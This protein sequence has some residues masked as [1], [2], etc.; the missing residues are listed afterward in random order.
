MSFLE[1]LFGGV[2]DQRREQYQDFVNRYEQGGPY[3]GIGADE[4]LQQYQQVA[5]QI[6]PDIYQQAAQEAFSRMA[7]QE[8]VQF[9]QFLERQ[10]RQQG[11]M[12]PAWD[13]DDNYYQDPGYLAQV[14]SRLQQQKS[15]MLA[16]LLGGSLEG[17]PTTDPPRGSMH[18]GMTSTGM[19]GMDQL[20]D[21]PL[22]KAALGGIAA[23]AMRRMMGGR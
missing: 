13:D 16:H 11:Y 2:N 3:A 18:R 7:P 12:D 19:G 5:G 17:D 22:A 14:T 23:M 9:G 6:P 8:R 10:A 21:N 4:A 1:S 15:G 20:R